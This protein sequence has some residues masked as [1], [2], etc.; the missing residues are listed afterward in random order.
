MWLLPHVLTIVTYRSSSLLNSL[1]GGVQCRIKSQFCF[2]YKSTIP[3]SSFP[4]SLKNIVS[5]NRYHGLVLMSMMQNVAES[6]FLF[7]LQ[8]LV[9]KLV[10]RFDKFIM[11]YWERWLKN[12]GHRIPMCRRHHN[13]FDIFPYVLGLKAYYDLF[14]LTNLLLTIMADKLK[15]E[16]VI[17]S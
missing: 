11:Y 6:C 4:C 3:E 1:E 7:C 10:F 17:V 9:D 2:I 15:Y 8:L 14:K 13:V 12:C 16:L 5:L